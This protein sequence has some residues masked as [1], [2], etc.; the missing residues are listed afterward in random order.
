MNPQ[1]GIKQ[2]SSFKVESSHLLREKQGLRRSQMM[3]MANHKAGLTGF[4]NMNISMTTL[5]QNK[6]KFDQ[7]KQ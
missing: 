3:L 2:A 5:H 1:L 4:S 6:G 7:Q